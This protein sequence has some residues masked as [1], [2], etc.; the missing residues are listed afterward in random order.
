MAGRAKFCI[1]EDTERILI[2]QKGVPE[3]VAGVESL[4]CP[5]FYTCQRTDADIANE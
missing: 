3:E 5:T 2:G 1:A 4:D